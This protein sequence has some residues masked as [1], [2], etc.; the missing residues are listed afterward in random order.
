[1]NKKHTKGVMKILGAD[2]AKAGMDSTNFSFW[3]VC[4]RRWYNPMR[5]IKGEFYY[6][7]INHL[8]K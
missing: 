6:K 1:M 7:S 3:E 5:Y 8:F 4:T 2:M